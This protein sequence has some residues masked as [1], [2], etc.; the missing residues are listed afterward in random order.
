[1][2]FISYISF[3]TL[4]TVELLLSLHGRTTPGLQDSKESSRR[5]IIHHAA[6]TTPPFEAPERRISPSLGL[7]RHLRPWW[8]ITIGG[9]CCCVFKDKTSAERTCEKCSKWSLFNSCCQLCGRKNFK[10]T[11]ALEGILWK[12]KAGDEKILRILKIQ[13]SERSQGRQGRQKIQVQNSLM[14]H[15]LF[16]GWADGGS[17]LFN[18]FK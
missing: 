11:C 4:K 9:V 2:L 15:P 17:R 3:G 12:I 7:D 1:M 10:K 5:T 14:I 13:L 6:L 8:T 18:V 16:G